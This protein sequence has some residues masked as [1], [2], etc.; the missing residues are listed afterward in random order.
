M[1]G[2]CVGAYKQPREVFLEVAADRG[3]EY[4]CPECGRLWKTHDVHEFTW[5]HLNLCI[6]A[7]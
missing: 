6:I 1:V 3:A 2:Q 4:P 7:T 5:R